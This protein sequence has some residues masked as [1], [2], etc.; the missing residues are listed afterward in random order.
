MSIAFTAALRFIVSVQHNHGF[1]TSALISIQH[2]GAI[3]DPMVLD[4][5]GLVHPSTQN[6][7]TSAIN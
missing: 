5:Y 6:A 4:A 1:S 3:A 7:C 2:I